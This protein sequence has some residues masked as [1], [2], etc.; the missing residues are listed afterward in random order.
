MR[1]SNLLFWAGA[2]VSGFRPIFNT[3][4]K[5]VKRYDSESNFDAWERGDDGKRHCEIRIVIRV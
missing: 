5:I 3:R 4:F 2:K 1:S